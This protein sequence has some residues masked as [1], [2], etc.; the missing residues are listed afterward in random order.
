MVSIKRRSQFQGGL[1]VKVFTVLRILVRTD[2]KIA[3][4]FEINAYMKMRYNRMVLY[5]RQ[6]QCGSVRCS[7]H[8]GTWHA[9]LSPGRY[10]DPMMHLRRSTIGG[11]KPKVATPSV[12]EKI[13]QYK[14]ENPT[15]FAWEIRDKLLSDSEY[16]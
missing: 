13:E 10:Y 11:S 14:R 12:V 3:P 2:S 7:C 1:R 4:L 15:I 16:F 9:F 5:M 8:Y 6:C